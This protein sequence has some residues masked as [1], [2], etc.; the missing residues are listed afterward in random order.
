MKIGVE[1]AFLRVRDFFTPSTLRPVWDIDA[2]VG[3]VVWTLADFDG[4]LHLKASLPATVVREGLL[5]YAA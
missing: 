3:V 4:R 1:Y 5:L 2:S